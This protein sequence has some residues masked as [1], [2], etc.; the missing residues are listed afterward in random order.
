MG[1]EIH[2]M[3]AL[4]KNPKWD[5]PAATTPAPAIGQQPLAAQQGSP[6]DDAF[7]AAAARTRQSVQPTVGRSE[8]LMTT[9]PEAITSG[10]V[11]GIPNALMA[12]PRLMA[13][14]MEGRTDPN[15]P[16]AIRRAFDTALTVAGGGVFGA[17]RGALGAA[18]GKPP[19]RLP[20][21]VPPRNVPPATFGRATSSDYRTTFIKAHPEID[22]D[23]WVHHAVPQKTLDLYPNSVTPAEIHSLENLRGIPLKSNREVHLQR[24]TKE[25][26]AFYNNHRVAS[27]Q[28]L[29]DF[30]SHIDGQ[31]G[32]LF[33]PQR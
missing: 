28:E 27:K 9:V 6:A 16:E 30:A 13:D 12:G 23:F 2:L 4:F 11:A 8:S 18:G 19:P 31:Y 14:V 5:D 25:W 15:S 1:E 32:H 33:V 17:E 26:N 22:G 10:I 24:I 7:A 29:L 21:T 3:S 20:P